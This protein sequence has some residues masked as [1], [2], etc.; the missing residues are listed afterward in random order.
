MTDFVAPPGP[1][2]ASTASG[3]RVRDEPATARVP[4]TPEPEGLGALVWTV[5][6]RPATGLAQVRDHVPARAGFLPWLAALYGLALGLSYTTVDRNLDVAI[7]Y[8]RSTAAGELALQAA[9]LGVVTAPLWYY[10]WGGV[11]GL[12]RQ[13]AGGGRDYREMRHLGVF[14]LLPPALGLVLAPVVIGLLASGDLHGPGGV[15]VRGVEI[16]LA[17]WSAGL[18]VVAMRVATTFAWPRA[19][20]AALV[21]WV[22]VVG[23]YVGFQYVVFTALFVVGCLVLGLIGIRKATERRVREAKA[24][25]AEQAAQGESAPPDA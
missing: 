18:S 16:G 8:D 15:A 5:L 11:L 19:T 13:L 9:L 7:Q 23:V 6:V 3:R 1:P 10:V 22:L 25:A 20:V 4:T 12:G 21:P 24:M 17:A 14:S 2:H